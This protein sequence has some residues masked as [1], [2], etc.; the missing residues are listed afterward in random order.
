[1]PPCTPR[2]WEGLLVCLLLI[3]SM[4]GTAG[5]VLRLGGSSTGI[6][7]MRVLGAAFHRQHPDATFRFVPDL[8]SSG[9]VKA[10][11]AGALDLAVISRPLKEEERRQ[12]LDEF[13]YGR[14]PWVFLVASDNPLHGVKRDELADFY[15]QRHE[16]WPDGSPVRLVVAPRGDADNTLIAT[17]GSAM[18]HA[19][20]Q[21]PF[22]GVALG[23]T[24]EQMVTQI[25]R[26]PGALGATSLAI[27]LAEHRALTPLAL[28]GVLPS[29][30]SLAD[31]R[32]PLFKTYRL[33]MRHNAGTPTAAFRAYLFTP[34]A[35]RLLERY[36]H[37][38]ANRQP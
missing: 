1:M 20:Q 32:Y 11:L 29:P 31:G 35:Q 5:A 7:V 24:D 9:G 17:L 18:A 22:D 30:T 21:L 3:W 12:G 26:T 28:D 16:H 14:T 23:N 37:W 38:V 2:K 36:G 15:A 4:D 8:S 25:E 19:L 10:L 13:E 33:V 34:E 27:V 6:A